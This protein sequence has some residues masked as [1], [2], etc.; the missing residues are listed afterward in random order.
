MLSLWVATAFD[1]LVIKRKFASAVCDS[2]GV[3]ESCVVVKA[4]RFFFLLVA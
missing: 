4:L 2:R 3:E 1:N